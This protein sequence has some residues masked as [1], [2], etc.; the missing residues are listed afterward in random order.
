[1]SV[2]TVTH[3][4]FDVDGLLLGKYKCYFVLSIK[5]VEL[6]FVSVIVTRFRDP[7]DDRYVHSK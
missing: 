1:M 7:D 6:N 4:L 5:F 3:V 2:K